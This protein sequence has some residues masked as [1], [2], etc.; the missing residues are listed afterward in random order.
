MVVGTSVSGFG[1]L[2]GPE[3]TPL[4]FFLAAP[5]LDRLTHLEARAFVVW[6]G[7]CGGGCGGLGCGCVLSVA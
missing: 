1:T 6:V 7:G 2:L 3:E 4:V 5:G